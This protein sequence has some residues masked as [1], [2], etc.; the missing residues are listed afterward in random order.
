[1]FLFALGAIVHHILMQLLLTEF[2]DR[3]QPKNNILFE[4]KGQVPSADTK[5]SCKN[6]DRMKSSP[7]SI[8][9]SI[10][11]IYLSN[12]NWYAQA[13]LQYRVIFLGKQELHRA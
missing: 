3:L 12:Q 2:G 10:M 9:N 8:S 1:M 7:E 4:K 6:T 13:R 5:P 11:L